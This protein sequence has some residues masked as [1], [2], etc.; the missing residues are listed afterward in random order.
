MHGQCNLKKEKRRNLRLRSMSQA[1]QQ[2]IVVES[3]LY[4]NGL[5]VNRYLFGDCPQKTPK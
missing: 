4:W 2:K 5:D 3:P 1:Q